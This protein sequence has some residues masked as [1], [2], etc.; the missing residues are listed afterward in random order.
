M[1]IAKKSD[2]Y[3]LGG[4]V[5]LFFLVPTVIALYKGYEVTQI[6]GRRCA[7]VGLLSD[8]DKIRLAIAEL[9]KGD[10]IVINARPYPKIPYENIDEVLNQNP[11]CCKVVIPRPEDK[12]IEGT[13]MVELS[14]TRRY[15]DGG[16][17]RLT[18]SNRR[19]FVDRCGHVSLD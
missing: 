18:K 12:I 16:E 13:V 2:W 10:S 1:K 8:E 15:R 3:L 19:Y 14:Y 6:R 4:L 11:G 9:E 7:E 5:V 17:E